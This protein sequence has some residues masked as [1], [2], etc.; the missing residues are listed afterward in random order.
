VFLVTGDYDID[1]LNR[2]LGR[3][4]TNPLARVARRMAISA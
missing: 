2:F 4:P 1:E 3:T